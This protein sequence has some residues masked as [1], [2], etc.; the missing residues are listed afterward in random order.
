V[1]DGATG[2]QLLSGAV[3]CRIQL[4]R[5][6]VAT[7]ARWG[8]EAADLA[9]EARQ[10]MVLKFVAAPLT[11]ALA[12]AGRPDDAEAVLAELDALPLGFARMVDSDLARARGWAAASRGDLATA[13][14]CFDAAAAAAEESG[15]TV[16][17]L[18]AVHDLV[19][20]GR[21]DC[22]AQVVE[23]AGPVEGPL[24]AARA[25]HARGVAERDPELLAESSVSFETLGAMLLA[26]EAAADAATTWRA[27]GEPR[28]AA[29]A[30]QRAARLA[31]HCEG[32]TTP[33][34]ATGTSARAVLSGRELEIARLAVTGASNREISSR[35]HLSLKTVENRLHGIYQKLGIENR[36]GLAHA[37]ADPA[38]HS[39]GR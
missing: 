27:G 5:G 24:P 21:R 38:T 30:E 29:A 1:S 14:A 36:K 11:E 10:L 6:R 19:R 13:Q 20:L 8:R 9:R 28:K 25:A 17:Q 15:D 3:L 4:A 37:L 34:L 7:A 26:A 12:L 16:W 2:T 35:L 33:A 18:A 22:A 32:A 39:S 23:L 31:A